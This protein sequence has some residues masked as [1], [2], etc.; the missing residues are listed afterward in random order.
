MTD[1]AMRALCHTI[2]YNSWEGQTAAQI[3]IDVL[4]YVA[5]QRG[6]EIRPDES[7]AYLGSEPVRWNPNFQRADEVI[8]RMGDL[9]GVQWRVTDDDVL[10]FFRA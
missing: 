1:E 4:T 3:V 5:T 10:T 2:I 7:L 6:V 8:T 9:W